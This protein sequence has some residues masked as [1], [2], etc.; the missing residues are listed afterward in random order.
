MFDLQVFPMSLSP[1][2]PRFGRRGGDRLAAT[3]AATVISERPAT[4]EA[5]T[6]PPK[7]SR[8]SKRINRKTYWLSFLGATA[9][10]VVLALIH[11][12]MTAMAGVIVWL[13]IGRLHD[14]GRSGWWTL[15]I[16]GLV[17]GAIVATWS[18]GVTSAVAVGTL[19][20]LGCVV[21]LGLIPGEPGANRFGPAPGRPTLVETA[22]VFR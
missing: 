17:F 19:V 4:T 8:L 6:P 3:A 18:F 9:V 11:I 2:E 15:A 14:L 21:A 22:D 20:E 10:S 13:M 1:T 12:R 16:I 5:V 7:V